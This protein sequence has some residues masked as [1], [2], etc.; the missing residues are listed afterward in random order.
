M[1]RSIYIICFLLVLGFEATAQYGGY[2]IRGFV[3]DLQTKTPLTGA[4]IFNKKLSRGSNVALD[5]SYSLKNIPAGT[6]TLHCSF[7]GYTAK[8]TTITVNGNLHIDFRLNESYAALNVIQI[9]GKRNAESEASAK[10]SE[11]LSTNVVNIISAQAIQLSPDITVANVLQRVS[12]VSV[13]RSGSGDGRYAIIRG[14]D[15]RYNY[16]LINGIK[17]PSPDNR[18]RY[19]PLDIFP[20]DLVERIE[21]HKTLTPDMEGDAI[22]GTVNMVMKNAPD[23]LYI[24]GSMSTGTSQTLLDRGYYSFPVSAINRQSPYEANGPSYLAKATDFTR[25]NLKYTKKDQTP[26][27]LG[28]LSIGNRF[29]DNRLGVIVSGSYQNTYRGYSTIFNPAEFREGGS[30]DIKHA[31]SREYSIQ[32][33]RTGL[34][35]KLDYRINNGNK[36]SL[37]NFYAILDEAQTRTTID[38]LLPAPRTRPGTGQ[39]WYYARSRFQRQTIYNSTLQGEHQIIPEKLKFTWSGVYSKATNQ[40]PDWAEYEYD[41]GFYTDPSTPNAPP[42]QHPNI[43]QNFNRTWWRNSDRDFSGYANLTFKNKIASIPY[44]I[45]AGGMYRDKHR[46]NFYQNYELRPVPNQDGS[47]Q[48][49]SGIDNF[50]WEVFNPAGT[51][52]H[53]NNYRANEKIS[54]GYAMIKFQLK[55]LET[56]I[57]LRLENTDQNFDTDVPITQA[58]KTGSITYLDE[59][60]SVHFKYMLN[61]KTNLRLSYFAS[62]SRPGFFEI[63]PYEF[64]G[65]NWTEKGNPELLHTTANNIDFRYEFFPKS[66]EQVLIGAFYKQIHNP[67]EYGFRFTGVQNQTVYQPNNFGDATN[68]GLELVYE[69]YIRSFGIRL[70]YTYTHSSITTTKFSSVVENGTLKP[71]YIDEER[72]LQGQSAHIANAALLY[73]NVN[74]GLDIQ[75]TW[76]YTGKRIV[77]VAPYYGFDYWQ[78]GTNLFDFSAEKKIGKCF[79]VFTK[80]QNLLNSKYEVYINKPPVNSIPAPYQDA[81]TGKTLAERSIY[82]QNYQLGLRY[83][84]K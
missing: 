58:A 5:G 26:N 10:K 76:Q 16:T 81:S 75:L 22:G 9:S 23:R 74:L 37:Y 33:T 53:A 45:T 21:V 30:L 79:S 78:K 18:Y 12:G 56:T 39:V 51:P 83:I 43:T 55:K 54:A 25:E 61:T 73:K 7:I 59:L 13:E 62:I 6:Y 29:F 84:F 1:Q 80:V 69:K 42:Y 82:G 67:I 40:I 38:T 36:I 8:D 47:H 44:T 28:S 41:G 70:N 65:E 17:I 66:N 2:T 52:A 72:P 32:Q 14:M 60:P 46:D 68:Y 15:Q 24:N 31:N 63:V 27:L 19:V 48:E 3:T 35:A 64:K 77:L 20:A 34:N 71:L 4:S 11:Q 57:G 49:W 50:N